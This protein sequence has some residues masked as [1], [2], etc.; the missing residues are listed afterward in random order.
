MQEGVGIRQ[1][2]WQTC[3]QFG[4]YQ[5]CDPK[6]QCIFSHLL[7]LESNT[8]LCQDAYD[9]SDTEIAARIAFTQGYYGAKDP[10]SSRVLFVNGKTKAAGVGL[11]MALSLT[12]AHVRVNLHTHTG[13]IDPWHWLSVLSAEGEDKA[14]FIDGTA[15]CANMM[16]ARSNDPENLVKAR[17]Q[18]ATVVAGW[19]SDAAAAHQQ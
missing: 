1:W 15:H 11:C 10:D 19:I 14:V 17:E 6:T 12:C 13:S 18:I 8:V 9:I 16:P 5:T 3:T 4:F 2:I 7:T